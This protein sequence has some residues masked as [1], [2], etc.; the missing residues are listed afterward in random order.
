MFNED[1]LICIFEHNP[2]ILLQ[3]EWYQHVNLIK[4]LNYYPGQQFKKLMNINSFGVIKIKLYFIFPKDIS[5]LNFIEHY[6]GWCPL[7]AILC[8]GKKKNE[9]IIYLKNNS[10]S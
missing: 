3:E 1:G 9:K 5:K 7:G 2:L 10:F 6:F 8:I 4:A